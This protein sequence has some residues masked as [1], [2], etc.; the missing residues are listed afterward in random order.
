MG[1]VLSTNVSSI[2]AQRNLLTVNGKLSQTFQRLSSGLR[3]NSAKDD[4]A[5]LQ[6]SNGLTS[7]VNGLT[8]ASRNANDGIS[9]AQVAEGAL[10]ETTNILQR[11]RDLAIQS[12]N[13]SNGPSERAALNAE[14]QQLVLEVDRIAN[15]TRFGSRNILTGTLT[16]SQFQVGAQAFETINLSINS[17]RAD[18]LGI[19]NLAFAGFATNRV[20]TVNATP[21][22]AMVADNLTYTVNG[23]ASTVAV[24]V[25][26][27]AQQIADKINSEVRLTLR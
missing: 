21:T 25:G 3:I 10:Q 9:L 12:A 7:Q 13:G 8:V 11:I 24:A 5:G 16:G 14:V 17:A 4:A 26:D 18:D 23:V 19:N 20:S 15:T 22:S 1:N 2:N 6:I 27:S